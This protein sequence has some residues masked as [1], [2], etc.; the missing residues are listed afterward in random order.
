M[1]PLGNPEYRSTYVARR[2]YPRPIGIVTFRTTI[3]RDLVLRWKSRID[4]EDSTVPFV[5]A[6]K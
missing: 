6:Q 2:T 3:G 5:P 1:P 4:S